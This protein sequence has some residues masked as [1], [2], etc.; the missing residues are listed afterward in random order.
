MPSA[1]GQGSNHGKL[2]MSTVPSLWPKP[3]WITRPVMRWNSRLVSAA[4]ASPA[5][6]QERTDWK[7]SRVM[8]SFLMKR[9]IVGGTQKVVGRSLRTTSIRCRA[10]NLSMSYPSTAEPEIHWP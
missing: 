9:Y 10:L 8:P 6:P 3:S 5:V 2:P 7:S 4:R 1:P